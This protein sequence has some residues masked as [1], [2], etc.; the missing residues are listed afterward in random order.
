MWKRNVVVLLLA[1]LALV[2]FTWI[3]QATSD[4]FLDLHSNARD[5]IGVLFVTLLSLA[6]FAALRGGFWTRTAIVAAVPLLFGVLAEF[7]WSDVDYPGIQIVLGGMM[8]GV[9]LLAC[10]FIAGPI[11]LWRARLTRRARSRP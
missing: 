8:A 6:A 3:A 10:L 5:T 11:I 1:A 9:A 7:L 4:I 2:G